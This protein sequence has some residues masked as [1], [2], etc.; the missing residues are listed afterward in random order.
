MSRL[1][2][3]GPALSISVVESVE[4][5]LVRRMMDMTIP[6]LFGPVFDSPYFPPHRQRPEDGK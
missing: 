4:H 3:A 1:N 5:T 6:V 2:I